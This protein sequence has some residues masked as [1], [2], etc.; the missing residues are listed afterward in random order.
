M[1]EAEFSFRIDSLPVLIGTAALILWVASERLLHLLG[2]RQGR[3]TER[4]TLSFY[5]LGVVTFYGAI[6]FSFLDATTFNWTTVGS[7]LSSAR[8]VGIPLLLMG[9]VV[10]ILSRL[11]LGK[12]FS[13]HVQTTEHHR[14]VTTGIYGLI[15]HPA[16]LGYLCLFVGFPV[17]FG[18]IGGLACAFASGIP[19]LIYRIRIEESAL[20][21]W[22]PD[23][24]HVYRAKTRRLIPFLW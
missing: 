21:R 10:R 2:L 1:L 9:F 17:T 7:H 3:P 5:W 4:E 19:A 20:E 14:L 6:V 23:E 18:S 8:Y 24:Y 11:A 22:F 16:Y 12:Q 13:G 15:R